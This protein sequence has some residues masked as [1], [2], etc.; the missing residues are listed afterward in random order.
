MIFYN[1]NAELSRDMAA[2]SAKRSYHLSVDAVVF[3]GFLQANEVYFDVNERLFTLNETT[4][5][6]NIMNGDFSKPTVIGVIAC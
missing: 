1:D 6:T 4:I 2:M 3:E 5:D